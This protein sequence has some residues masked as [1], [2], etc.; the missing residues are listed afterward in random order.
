MGIRWKIFK[1]LWQRMVILFPATCITASS[2]SA[3]LNAH[4]VFVQLVAS[5]LGL[6]ISI[7]EAYNE[8]AT[9][10]HAL[11]IGDCRDLKRW[12]GCDAG[13]LY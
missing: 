5:H 11:A 1:N 8:Y 9:S 2:M 4:N 12:G 3:L 13:E 6:T 10:Y 7:F